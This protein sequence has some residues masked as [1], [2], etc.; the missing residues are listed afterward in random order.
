MYA[1]ACLVHVCMRVW[2]IVHA[3]ACVV[4]ACDMRVLNI[5]VVHT[6]YAQSYTCN[7]AFLFSLYC[8]SLDGIYSHFFH[9]CNRQVFERASIQAIVI[10]SV[11]FCIVKPLK[12]GLCT[13]WCFSLISVTR[14]WLEIFL[15]APG[16]DLSSCPNNLPVP[17]VPIVPIV[18]VTICLYSIVEK[19]TLRIKCLAHAHTT[20][21]SLALAANHSAIVLLTVT[22]I[23]LKHLW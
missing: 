19:G 7:A 17:I 18:P 23:H 10:Y 2:C 13:S 14:K 15:L 5:L 22:K 11:A 16:W 12:H 21:S 3:F 6:L 20:V 1:F 4:N 8:R 9:V